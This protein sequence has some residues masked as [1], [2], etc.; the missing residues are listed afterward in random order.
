MR[1]HLRWT[2]SFVTT[3][4]TLATL[5]IAWPSWA[6]PDCAVGRT[7]RKQVFGDA[8]ATNLLLTVLPFVVVGAVSLGCERIGRARRLR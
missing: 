5:A 8:F 3:L 6:C 4:T 2:V 1:A 7:A